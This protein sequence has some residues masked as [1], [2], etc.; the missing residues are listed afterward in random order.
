MA[1]ECAGRQR[2]FWKMH[3]SLF[4]D[5]NRLGDEELRARAKTL[6]LDSGQFQKCIDADAGQAVDA[7]LALASR[8]GVTGTPTSFL[9]KQSSD[10]MISVVKRISGA[11]EYPEFESSIE[12]LLRS[13][14]R[15][16]NAARPQQ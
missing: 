14:T 7:D 16:S 9:G 10:G 12:D 6:D 15:A 3:D 5:R 4:G 11:K 13:L 8:L 1:A 2:Q